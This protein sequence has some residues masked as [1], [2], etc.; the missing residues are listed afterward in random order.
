MRLDAHVDKRQEVERLLPCIGRSLGVHEVVLLHVLQTIRCAK[1][2]IV[3]PKNI[4]RPG[5]LF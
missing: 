3:M 2:R 5:R 1:N 4:R